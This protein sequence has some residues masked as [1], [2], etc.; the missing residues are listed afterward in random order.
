[1]KIVPTTIQNLVK[2]GDSGTYYAR[3]RVNGRLIIRSLGTKTFTPARLRLPDKLKEIREAEPVGET[4]SGGLERDSTFETVAKLYTSQVNQD[5]KLRASS[6]EARLRPLAMLRR[7][8]PELFG[9]EVRRVQA[10]SINNYIADFQRGKWPYLPTRAKS[11]TVAGNS[12]STFNKLVTCLRNAFDLA[13]KAHVIAKNPASELTYKPLRKK[14]LNLPS[15]K[16]FASIIHHIRTKAGQ[17]RIAADFVEGLAYS[18][19]RLEEAATQTW[20]DLDHERRMMTVNG[21]KTD[22]SSRVIP[23]TEA[24][25]QLTLRIKAHRQRFTGL[26]V[27]ATDKVFEAGN[28]AMSLASACSAIGVKKMTHHDLRHLFATTCIESGVDVPTVAAWLGHVD[29]GVLAMQTY[30]HIRPSHSTEAAK[31][32]KF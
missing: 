25:Y 12:N 32:V 6:R 22:G 3:V 27:T 1:M 4:A 10:V 14:L 17:G 18:G 19:M 15:K 28:A 8:W 20:G 23:M 26:P 5:P 16:Q 13:V 31:K 24:F 2:D 30:G 29:G 11:K 9:M 21:T 7:T